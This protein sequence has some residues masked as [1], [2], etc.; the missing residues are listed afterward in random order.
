MGERTCSS[1]THEDLSS[2]TQDP[3]KKLD[4]AKCATI[5]SAQDR[6]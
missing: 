2:N 6:G 1:S 4:V 3:L 5:A